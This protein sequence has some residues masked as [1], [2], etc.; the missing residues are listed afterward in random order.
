MRQQTLITEPACAFCGDSGWETVTNERYP[1]GAVR[2][3]EHC[4]AERAARMYQV[5]GM[6]EDEKSATLENTIEAKD[7]I[8]PNDTN[9]AKKCNNVEAL[10]HA[11]MFVKGD[12]PNL[13][14]FGAVGVGKTRIL[15]AILNDLA[16]MKTVCRFVRVPMLLHQVARPEHLEEDMIEKL[17]RV[18]VLGLDDVGAAQGTDFARR[19]LQILYDD[20]LDRGNRTIWTSNLNLTTLRRHLEDDD[21]LPSRIAGTCKVVQV[22][23]DRDWR[24]MK[25]RA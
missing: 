16:R 1:R 13:Y 7:T 17:A 3:C 11:R 24:V 18:P 22:L 8:D 25:R 10:R 19:T 15:C 21:R 23:G 2:P 12:H 20:R 6:P 5:H 9:R 14:I 4:R